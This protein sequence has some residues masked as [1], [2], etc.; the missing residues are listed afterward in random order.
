MS[1]SASWTLLPTT[2]ET[3]S[4]QIE[5]NEKQALSSLVFLGSGL[6]RPFRRDEKSDFANASGADLVKSA[7]G[8]ILGTRATSAQIA[9]EL[10]WRP[11][12]GSLLPTLRHSNNDDELQQIAQAFVVDALSR[13]EPRVRVTGFGTFRRSSVA[14]GVEDTLEV[15]VEYDIIDRNVP[16]N[17]VVLSGQQ[18]TIELEIGVQ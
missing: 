10:P 4:I 12:F 3:P 9:G 6:I 5:D 8:L 18:T 1:S 17:N 14:G 16:G 7:V 13:W 15:K 2:P 11:E